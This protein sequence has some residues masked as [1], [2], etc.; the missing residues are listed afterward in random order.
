MNEKTIV[1]GKFPKS[2]YLSIMCFALCFVFLIVTV[3]LGEMM[4]SGEG[5]VEA[6][7]A[8]NAGEGSAVFFYLTVVLISVSIYIALATKSFSITV[9]TKRVYGTALFGKQVDLPLDMISS[10]SKAMF[11]G[12]GVATSSGLIRF[13]LLENQSEVYAEITKLLLNRQNG[14]INNV[15]GSDADELK[16][17]K[18]L[19]D[20]GVISQEEFVAKKK[21]ILDL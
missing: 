6:Y 17:Y 20:S 7:L 5:F 21:Q 8:P 19:L 11:K 15:N 14:T 9:T 12:V 1:H 4:H 13:Y 16:K 2:N 10:I 3:Y 18:D